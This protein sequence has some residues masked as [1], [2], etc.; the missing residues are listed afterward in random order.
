MTRKEESYHNAYLLMIGATTYEKLAENG[1]FFLPE[2][3]QDPQVLLAY[4]EEMEEYEKCED[5]IQS[6]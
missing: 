5:I 1:E 3:H 4:Y 2:N 6:I